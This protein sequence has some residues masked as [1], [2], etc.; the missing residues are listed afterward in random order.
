MP[1]LFLFS[2]EMAQ[3]NSQDPEIQELDSGLRAAFV[4]IQDTATGYPVYSGDTA[5]DKIYKDVH[6]KDVVA[7]EPITYG[8]LLNIYFDKDILR[9]RKAD[10]RDPDKFANSVALTTADTNSL[11]RCAVRTAALPIP[12]TVPQFLSTIPGEMTDSPT[13][14]AQIIQKVGDPAGDFFQFYFH[15]PA[16]VYSLNFPHLDRSF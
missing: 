10:A 7:A 12:K 15:T 1:E 8:N 14:A 9:A 5:A 13:S 6:P 3:I 16:L 4:A 11:V 2:T